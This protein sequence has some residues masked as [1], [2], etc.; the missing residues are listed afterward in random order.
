MIPFFMRLT[1]RRARTSV[2]KDI[3][4]P[5]A[6]PVGAPRRVA[7][8]VPGVIESML[9][10][11]KGEPDETPFYRD[12]VGVVKK[13]LGSFLLGCA[14]TLL[15][16]N[17]KRL[18]A[19]G[20]AL[21]DEAF[22]ALFMRPD[23]TSAY[24]L[25]T[26]ISGAA[27]SSYTAIRAAGK[28]GAV[29]YGAREATTLAKR[30]GGDNV[31]VFCYDWRQGVV[32]VAEK[33]N[34]FL[35]EVRALTGA[36][37]VDLCGCSYGCQVIAQY[38]YAGGGG[39]GRVVFNAPAW[40]GTALF[41]GLLEDDREKLKFNVP[42]AAR[43]L[44]R[45]AGWEL[46][47]EP[48]ARRVPR[49]VAEALSHSMI[50]R[51]LTGGLLYCPG[52]W[53]CCANEDYE[54]LR[55][56]YLCPDKCAA[57][58]EATDAAHRGVMRHIP[59]IL[60]EAQKAGVEMWAVMNDG[61][62][63]MAGKSLD[64]DGVIDAATG[65]GGVC[66]PTERRAEYGERSGSRPPLPMAEKGGRL[67]GGNKEYRDVLQ[68]SETTVFPTC[69]DTE[70]RKFGDINEQKRRIPGNSKYVSPA[71]NYDL[72]GGLLPDRTWVVTGQVHG[73]SCWDDATRDLI[74]DLLLTGKPETADSD[75]AYPRFLDSHCPADGVSLRLTGPA[76]KTLRAADGPRQAVIRNDSEKKTVLVLSVTVKGIP[77]R[78]SPVCGL[79][80]PGAS[81]PVTLTPIGVAAGAARG[82]IR[83]RYIK[84]DPLPL[85][86]SRKQAFCVSQ[87]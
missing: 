76:E 56:K 42:A 60:A 12:A 69:Q 19:F 33:L 58:I 28:W 21:T 73:Q 20:E 43:V 48:Y 11:H 71:G 17:D 72:S 41:R 10:L 77:Y 57:L 83:L 54:A 79:L 68:T 40:Q 62:P 15:C 37:T 75:P 29:G 44:T 65:S 80:G 53:S 24:D 8:I 45:F 59:E 14:Q 32:S 23:G 39:I 78:V 87:F 36:E 84:S 18:T 46:D 25:D 74:A 9:V 4:A 13:R 6:R 55:D 70:E 64:G 85:V 1:P 49:R 35:R 51:A 50:R 30:I 63:L 66:A 52:L 5:A 67:T 2:L 22:G 47:L 34:A 7:V 38:F 81:V 26:V 61:T 27:E 3:D 82:V 16:R 31:F 86:H